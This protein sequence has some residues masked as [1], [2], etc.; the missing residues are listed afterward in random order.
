V[1]IDP[2]ALAELCREL[3]SRGDS[4]AFFARRMWF[5]VEPCSH[6]WVTSKGEPWHCADCGVLGIV[7]DSGAIAP[8]A[9][10]RQGCYLS[11]PYGLSECRLHRDGDV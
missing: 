6:A 9:C 3:E 8:R 7:M 4:T 2:R 11:V 1:A 5:T 10:Y